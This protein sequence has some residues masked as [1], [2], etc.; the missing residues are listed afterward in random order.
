L[1][2]RRGT[3]GMSGHARQDPASDHRGGGDRRRSRG[4][5]ALALGVIYPR[6]GAWYVRS[7]VVPQLEGSAARSRSAA[8]TSRSATQCCAGCGARP[9]RQRHPAGA[10]RSGRRD[11]RHLEL[12][13]ATAEI[14]SIEVR[15]QACR[16][17]AP[18]TA[19]AT[20]ICAPACWAGRP[21][22]SP[23]AQRAGPAA[24]AGQRARHPPRGRRPGPRH[25]GGAG[26]CRHLPARRHRGDHRAAPGRRRARRLAAQAFGLAIW[27]PPWPS[28]S[29]SIPAT[30]QSIQRWPRRGSRR[31]PRRRRRRWWWCRA[32]GLGGAHHHQRRRHGR[33]VGMRG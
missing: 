13:L 30:S 10:A 27:A 14:D 8:S 29:P 25:R 21:R 12:V 33:R 20:S 16:C 24:C 1:A 18:P 32:G 4:R 7:Q 6:A 5:V 11:L 22:R 15:G 3:H 31:P 2:A 26:G 9:R 28:T 23:A 19:P 17:S